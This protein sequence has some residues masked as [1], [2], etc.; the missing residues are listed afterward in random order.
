VKQD[1][2]AKNYA[3]FA[4][5]DF[6]LKKLCY[7]VIVK[8]KIIINAPLITTHAELLPRRLLD[9]ALDRPREPTEQSTRGN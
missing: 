9:G 2:K 1:K 7:E 8:Q 5:P 4:S 6:F 3:V